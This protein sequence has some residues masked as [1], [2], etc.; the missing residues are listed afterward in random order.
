VTKAPEHMTVASKS[1][2]RRATPRHTDINASFPNET[3]PRTWLHRQGSKPAAAPTGGR[4]L[5]HAVSRLFEMSC[6]RDWAQ[7]EYTV[8]RRFFDDLTDDVPSLPTG[9]ADP[10]GHA[11]APV[12]IC[13]IRRAVRKKEIKPAS[14]IVNSHGR[15]R[16]GGQHNG[17]PTRAP[18][19]CVLYQRRFSSLQSIRRA[20]PPSRRTCR[21]GVSKSLHD[22]YNEKRAVSSRDLVREHLTRITWNR[23]SGTNLDSR[24][25][26]PN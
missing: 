22:A 25:V 16:P 19:A 1:Y 5:N 4:L 12:A 26:R 21:P 6:Y 9:T 2:S 7:I 3:L 10:G 8:N 18:E 23:A 15:S 13:L 24:F 14:A 17:A 11:P 20:A